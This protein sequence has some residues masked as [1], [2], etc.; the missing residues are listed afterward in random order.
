MAHDKAAAT[1]EAT[2]ASKKFDAAQDAIANGDHHGGVLLL[3]DA[4]ELGHGAVG[5]G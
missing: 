2:P 1:A 4:A 3:I 5:P